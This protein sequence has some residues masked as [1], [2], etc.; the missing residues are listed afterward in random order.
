MEKAEE[1]ASVGSLSSLVTHSL[2]LIPPS[3]VLYL[4]IPQGLWGLL[5]VFEAS[6]YRKQYT[7]LLGSF[8][9]LFIAKFGS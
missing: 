5:L 1:V 4:S 6:N 8:R 2:Y 3:L 9:S 7:I